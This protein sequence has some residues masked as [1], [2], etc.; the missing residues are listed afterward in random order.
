MQYP[1]LRYVPEDEDRSLTIETR[2]LVAKVIDNTG[3][4]AP[5]VE[6]PAY[7]NPTH[8]FTPFTHHLGYHGIRTLYNREER[9]NLVVPFVSWL[10]LQTAIMDGIEPDPIDERA[11]FGMGRGW[12]LRMEQA[13]R[14]AR[15]SLDPLPSMRMHYSLEIQPAEPDG[16]DFSVRFVFE[17]RPEKGSAR[18]RAAWPCY[19]NGYDDVRFFYPRRSTP[20]AWEWAGL[21]EKPRIIIGEPVHYEHDQTAYFAEEQ[22]MPLGYGLLGKRALIIML[23]D[24]GV[25]LFV[26]NCGGHFFCSPVQNPAWDFQWVVEDYPLHEATGFDGRIIYADFQG[27]EQVLARYHEWLGERSA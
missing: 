3:L 6:W 21:G 16:L 27:P 10:N 19:M 2:D 23:S 8:R 24:P 9:R 11:A 14:G 4:L 20:G 18:F 12:P 22:A 7:F 25:R 5:V 15:L 1:E 17:R 13:G 26:V